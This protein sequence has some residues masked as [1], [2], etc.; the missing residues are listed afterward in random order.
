MANKSLHILPPN[1]RN[2]LA[3]SA[4]IQLRQHPPMLLLLGL[5]PLEHLRRRRIIRPQRII[6]IRINPRIL[7][8]ITDRQRQNFLLAQIRKSPRH[9]HLLPKHF[10]IWALVILWS[11]GIGHWSL[12]L[13]R[14][15][16]HQ[17]TLNLVLLPLLLLII[18]ALA[19]TIVAYGTH[20]TFG[21]FS[22]GLS[23][24][25]FTRQY[26]WPLIVLSILLCLILIA[27][28][29]AGKRRA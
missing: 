10:G 8:L 22:H 28:V 5:H 13:S 16:T 21:Q 23:L 4:A 12:T 17:C 1:Q 18:A 15:A 20:P 19:A 9:R 24:I 11:L 2:M 26:Q 7:L 29:V 6:N 3:K 14:S 27:L 25:L